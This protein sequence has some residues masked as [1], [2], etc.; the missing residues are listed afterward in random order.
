MYFRVFQ[1]SSHAIVI[2]PSR[3][4][5]RGGGGFLPF[6]KKISKG[7]GRDLGLFLQILDWGGGVNCKYLLEFLEVKQF[8]YSSDDQTKSEI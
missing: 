8:L 1:L 7:M 3:S 6:K 4:V 2:P 5:V